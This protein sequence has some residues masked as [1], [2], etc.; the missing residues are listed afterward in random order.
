MMLKGRDIIH[1]EAKAGRPRNFSKQHQQFHEYL[2]SHYCNFSFSYKP[3]L[4]KYITGH[5]QCCEKHKQK[6]ITFNSKENIEEWLES[7]EAKN[8]FSLNDSHDSCE[9]L[10]EDFL[11]R[12]IMV[13]TTSLQEIYEDGFR[14]TLF[15]LRYM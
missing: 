9:D 6:I 8:I 2:Q 11:L 13:I 7:A 15:L 12:S 5:I 4:I 1:V 10:L 3:L 14:C